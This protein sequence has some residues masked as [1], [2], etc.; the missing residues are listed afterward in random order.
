VEA[1]RAGQVLEVPA[2]MPTPGEHYTVTEHRACQTMEAVTWLVQQW[3]GAFAGP[4][5]LQYVKL[6]TIP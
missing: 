2:L 4:D 3:M 1:A 5:V 6:T